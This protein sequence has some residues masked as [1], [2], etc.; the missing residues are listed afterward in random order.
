MRILLAAAALGT[1]VLAS[2][3]AGAGTTPAPKAIHT[4]PAIQSIAMGGHR[5]AY[6]LETL[7]TCEKKVCSATCNRVFVWDISAGTNRRVSGKQTCHANNS[8]TGAGVREMAIAGE[9][10]AW[11]VNQGGNTESNDYLYTASL[12]GPNER[13]LA[14]A[15]RF[16]DVGGILK[17]T[18]IGNLVGSG[19]LLAVNRWAT[20]ETGAVTRSGLD[21]IGG[22]GLRR[23]VSGQEAMLAQAADSGRI[24]VLRPGSNVDIYNANGKRL[25][26]VEPSSARAIALRRDFLLVLT[27]TR[28]LEIYNARS[29]AYL[30]SWPVPARAAADLDA[31]AGVAV[32]VA[33][34]RY[35]GEHFKVHV[36][37]L[38]TGKDVVLATGRWYLRRSAELE[39]PGL[40]YARDRHN[41]VFIPLKRVLAAVS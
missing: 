29:G 4:K 32:Y 13:R 15:R 40:V 21:V 10:M 34:P 5:M 41:L 36:L 39:A 11:I 19:N 6:D 8:S 23:V 24:A 28:T 7:V 3:A 18:W 9:R 33:Y 26:K 16:G 12:P 2:V 38:T 25:R 20:D 37:H 27:E 35:T 1:M 22:R 17:G 30:R 31:Y 14:A